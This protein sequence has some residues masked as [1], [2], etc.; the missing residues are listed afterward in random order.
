MEIKYHNYHHLVREWCKTAFSVARLAYI[1]FK[2]VEQIV[3]LSDLVSFYTN[4]ENLK[5]EL[6]TEMGSQI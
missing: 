6:T 3:K 1:A 2:V 4:G 5:N